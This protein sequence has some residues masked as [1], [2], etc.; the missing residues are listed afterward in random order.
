MFGAD[1]S[2]TRKWGKGRI[3]EAYKSV[4]LL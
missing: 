3:E 1:I 2:E 4:G